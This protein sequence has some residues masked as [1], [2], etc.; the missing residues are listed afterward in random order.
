MARAPRVRRRLGIVPVAIGAAALLA[1][2]D[3][4]SVEEVHTVEVV[5]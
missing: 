4:N 5:R 1:C 3:P 2:D